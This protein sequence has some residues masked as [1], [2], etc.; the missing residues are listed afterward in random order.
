[1]VLYDNH[2]QGQAISLDLLAGARDLP[3]QN[4]LMGVLERAG[5]LD[6]AVA[7]LPDAGAITAR[8]AAGNGLTRPELREVMA[9]GKLWLSAEIDAGTLPDDPALE[10]DLFAY[11]P[12]VLGHDYAVEVRRHRLRRE[13]I[14]TAVTND[15]LNRLGHAAFGRLV[16]DS[17]MDASVVAKAAIIAR[18]AFDLGTVWR[19][20]EALDGAVPTE[21]QYRVESA[22]RRLHEATARALLAAPERLGG[23]AK[24]VAAPAAWSDR[25]G[26]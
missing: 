10:A 6:R 14:G 23:I 11:F 18:D 2:Q 12:A 21:A 26:G 9:H 1:M 4:A 25:A 5:I 24:S 8:T 7:G 13:L 16:T 19:A 22:M 3:A 17:G 15:L 20:V